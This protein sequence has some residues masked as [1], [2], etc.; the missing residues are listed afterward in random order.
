MPDQRPQRQPVVAPGQIQTHAAD[1]AVEVSTDVDVETLDREL[2]KLDVPQWLPIDG[3]GALR[4]LLE[5]D[6][7]GP[8]KT[9][10]GGW[11]D[12][13]TGVQFRDGQSRLVSVGGLPIKN[14]AGYDVAKLLIGSRGVFGRVQTVTLRTAR[15]PEAALVADVPV[16]GEALP[17]VVNRL[18][19]QTAPPTWLILSPTGL[20][21]GWLGTSDELDLLTPT[22]SGSPER[23][24]LANDADERQQT[25]RASRCQIPSGSLPLAMADLG[26]C[27]G[28]SID[29]VAGTIWFDDDL[30]PLLTRT[31]LRLGGH[32]TVHT[33]EGVTCYGIPLPVRDLL[34]RLKA[35]YDPDGNLSPLPTFA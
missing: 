24:S 26:G 10:F 23:R 5:V 6:S 31:A 22:I 30:A 4:D 21:A 9:T 3:S 18:L 17:D 12:R 7:T 29:P 33:A 2:S 35:E 25:S 27:D 19:V 20:R 13:T 8:L 34:T 32:A 28:W 11:R 1:M 14:V 15:R 16:D